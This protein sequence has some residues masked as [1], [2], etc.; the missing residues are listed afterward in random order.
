[1]GIPKALSVQLLNLSQA[2]LSN[3]ELGDLEAAK[4]VLRRQTVVIVVETDRSE[5]LTAG[6]MQRRPS[7]A[8][9]T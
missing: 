2:I 5:D 6:P 9:Y 8:R 3:L 1:V 7:S 4:D